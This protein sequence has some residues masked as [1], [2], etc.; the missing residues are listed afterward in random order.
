MSR[1]PL[2]K[3]S[4]ES[5]R[6]RNVG[7]IKE[8]TLPLTPLHALIGPNDSGKSTLLETIAVF[9]KGG[10]PDP[11]S[12]VTVFADGRALTRYQSEFL[13]IRHM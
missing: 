10:Y 5:I 9:T 4:I 3:P 2:R 11:T 12:E 1:D 7:C 8:V 13:S 6:V